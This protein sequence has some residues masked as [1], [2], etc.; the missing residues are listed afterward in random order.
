MQK[1]LILTL[2]M[3]AASTAA[4]AQSPDPAATQSQPAPVVRSNPN[5]NNPNPDYAATAPRQTTNSQPI[6]GVLLR[7]NS[8][9]VVQTISADA[10]GT[11]LRVE[12]GIANVNVHH[13]EHDVEILV[14]LPGGQTTLL[15]D[16]L[17]T[18]NADTNTVRVLKGEAEAYPGPAN[19]STKPI[20]IKEDHQLNFSASA[21]SLRSVEVNDSRQLTAD[22]LPGSDGS[23][24][25]RNPARGYSYAPY[26]DGFYGYGYPYPYYPYGWGYGYPYYGYGL[27]LGFGYY[28]GFRGYRGGFGGFRGGFRR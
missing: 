24:R 23:P 4:L 8:G 12:R 1:S 19:S 27:G 5:S 6:A 10:N 14:D 2:V 17:Y 13:P 26:G 16:G 9:S 25:G 22:L 3:A 18:F 7:V 15:K 28:G 21:N 11:E 20:R